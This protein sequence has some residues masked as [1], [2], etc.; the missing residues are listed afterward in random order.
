MNLTKKDLEEIEKTADKTKDVHL[1][2][3][4]EILRGIEE[5]KELLGKRLLTMA[6][7][8]KTRYDD[9]AEIGNGFSK[10]LIDAFQSSM[11]V[12]QTHKLD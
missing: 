1:L 10:D 3:L 9:E 11:E 8:S 4:I 12:A 2:F 7:G 5:V 6:S